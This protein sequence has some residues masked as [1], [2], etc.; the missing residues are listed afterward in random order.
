MTKGE[1]RRTP[2]RMAHTSPRLSSRRRPGSIGRPV[3]PGFRRGD[4]QGGVKALERGEKVLAAR[5]RSGRERRDDDQFF[6][7]YP[8]RNIH[9]T[10]PMHTSRNPHVAPRLHPTPTSALSKK[11]HRNP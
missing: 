6:N 1:E 10:T 11:L 4:N 9:V 5:R 2:I 3:G 8:V 7:R